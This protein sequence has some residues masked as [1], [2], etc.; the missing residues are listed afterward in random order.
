MARG[1]VLRVELPSPDGS[2]E[3][4]GRRPAIAIQAE[5]KGFS[6]PTLLV[7]P[8]TSNLEALR[9][10]YTI[11]VEPSATNGLAQQ[12]VLLVFQLRAMDRA[13]ITGTIGK[14][15]KEYIDQLNAEMRRLLAL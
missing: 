1:D 6:T 14:L 12:S 4:A 5:V 7:V 2:R 11:R 10:P 8:L 15:E 13:R 3:Q 9:F